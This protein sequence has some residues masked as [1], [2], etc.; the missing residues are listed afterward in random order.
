[1][2][3]FIVLL[4]ILFPFSAV[5][6]PEDV[7]STTG[8]YAFETSVG[9]RVGAAFGLLPV[10]AEDDELLSVTSPVLP[11]VEIHE[12]KEVGGIMQMRKV[13]FMPLE[14]NKENQLRPMGYHLMLMDLKGPLKKGSEFPLTLVFKKAGQKTVIVPVLAREAK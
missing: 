4:A 9:M 11:R 6:Q 8:L 10:L 5:A 2:K 1:M 14:K 13:G 7:G 3:K 12:M